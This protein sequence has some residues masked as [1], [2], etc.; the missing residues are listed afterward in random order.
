[1]PATPFIEPDMRTWDGRGWEP[2][3]TYHTPRRDEGSTK[4]AS[5]RWIPASERAQPDWYGRP[6]VPSTRAGGKGGQFSLR[7]ERRTTEWP[8]TQDA[9]GDTCNPGFS[10]EAR[11]LHRERQ[12][13]PWEAHFYRSS[14]PPGRRMPGARPEHPLM[15][16]N[17]VVAGGHVPNRSIHH[18]PG[19]MSPDRALVGE[20]E[21]AARAKADKARMRE[22]AS[23]APR[24]GGR[25]DA[26]LQAR[27][28][29]LTAAEK[30]RIHIPP[31]ES[32]LITNKLHGRLEYRESPWWVPTPP[33]VAMEAGF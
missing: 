33:T 21:K 3:R 4:S 32:G 30:R 22:R 19:Y 27:Q 14:T 12:A 15:M 7:S 16:D 13:Q 8:D 1:M 18:R 26:A 2:E 20:E 6:G 11:P 5:G 17:R 24:G 28:R 23:S 31:P 29:A 10:P 9:S 25:G